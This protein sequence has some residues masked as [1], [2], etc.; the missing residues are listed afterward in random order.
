M[1][2]ILHPKR[3]SLKGCV[4]ALGTFDGVHL[5]HR[6]VI[7]RAVKFAKKQRVPS[8]VMTFDPHPQH[9]VAPERGLRL[10]T[11]LKEREE[12]F[13]QLGV[14]GVVVIRFTEHTRKMSSAEFVDKYLVGRLGVRR[15]FVGYDYAFGQGRKGAIKDL[16]KLGEKYGFAVSVVPAVKV[17]N[18]AVKSRQI[19]NLISTGDFA[20]AVS[21]L[22]HPYMIAGKV[23]K[24]AGRGTKLGFPTA[25]L[26]VTAEKLVPAHG[27]YAGIVNGKKCAVNI[28]ARPTFS[29]G[30]TLVEVHIPRFKGNIRGKRL[31]VQLVARLRDEKQFADVEELK[32]QIRKDIVSLIRLS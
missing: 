7:N 19:R 14:D 10:L 5:G 22:G 28:G 2:I 29:A 31:K 9:L 21:L 26:Q 16:K 4:V 23:V 32:K 18:E 25:N 27:V 13:K 11:T 12:L 15:V 30:S 20:K 1:R 24:G 17:K 8:I 6:K 3:K